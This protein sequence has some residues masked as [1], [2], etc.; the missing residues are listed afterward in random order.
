MVE[1]AVSVLFY[2]SELQRSWS[3]ELDES[4]CPISRMCQ[5]CDC[6][7]NPLDIPLP[8]SASAVEV[9]P[10][11][12]QTAVCST[13]VYDLHPKILIWSTLGF[14][15]VVFHTGKGSQGGQF[16]GKR[17]NKIGACRHSTIASAQ[18]IDAL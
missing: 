15:H 9:P 4:T 6:L 7:S 1:A 12:L 11:V 13:R 2:S 14:P 5:C 10:C 16:V 8:L 17:F 18:K 3:R